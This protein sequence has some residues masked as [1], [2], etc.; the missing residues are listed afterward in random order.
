MARYSPSRWAVRR[1]PAFMLAVL[2]LT[3]HAL[4]FDGMS[5]VVAQSTCAHQPTQWFARATSGTGTTWGTAISTNMPATYHAATHNTATLAVDL[6]DYAT[7]GQPDSAVE[8]GWWQGYWM[9]PGY[10]FGQDFAYPQGYYTYDGGSSGWPL[11][12]Q[13]PASHSFLFQISN[14]EVAGNLNLDVHDQS[15]SWGDFNVTDP[16]YFVSYPRTNVS[17]PQIVVQ[18]GYTRD[19]WLGGNGGS[20]TTSWGYYQPQNSQTFLAWGSFTMCDDSPYWIQ[21]K[22]ASS[23]KVGGS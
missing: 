22:S 21:A 12:G 13:L 3:A 23:F 6:V 20:G 7:L 1:L 10:D 5:T 8:L 18:Q 19:V 17:N 16:N 15:G 9:Y 11:T 14:G 4:F 2:A